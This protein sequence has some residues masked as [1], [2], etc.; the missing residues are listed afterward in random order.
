MISRG[1]PIVGGKP[2][3]SDKYKADIFALSPFGSLL[4]T[5]EEWKKKCELPVAFYPHLT[6]KDAME[7]DGREAYKR[8]YC[9]DEYRARLKFLECFWR[10]L[11][12][13]Q[14]MLSI[15]LQNVI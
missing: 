9:P 5:A 3:M 15:S 12:K 2:I 8:G 1:P 11:H 13:V 7:A 10:L 4:P 6:A 14:C